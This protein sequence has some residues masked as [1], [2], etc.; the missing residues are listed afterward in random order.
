MIFVLQKYGS[1]S[2]YANIFDKTPYLLDKSV[3][4]FCSE[5]A[6]PMTAAASLPS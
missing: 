6:L 2:N 3:Y 5:Y 4:Y 1:D